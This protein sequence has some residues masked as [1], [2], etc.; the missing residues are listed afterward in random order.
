MLF[1]CH[2][3]VLHIIAEAL[4]YYGLRMNAFERAEVIHYPEVWYLGLDSN[5]IEG[6]EGSGQNH[7]Y[8]DDNGSYIKV[9]LKK[10]ILISFRTFYY[11]SK[12][13]IQN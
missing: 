10:N 6:E 3:I 12:F 9:R 4:R 11:Y 8:D 2:L 1:A 5:K 13:L 7:G